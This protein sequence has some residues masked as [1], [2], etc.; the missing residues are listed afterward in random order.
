MRELVVFILFVCSIGV[1]AETFKTD[2]GV[3][4]SLPAENLRSG[5]HIVSGGYSSL[6]NLNYLA[7]RQGST[8]GRF[9]DLCKGQLKPNQDVETII[10]AIQWATAD[11]D[12]ALA[13][14]MTERQYDAACV[15]SVRVISKNQCLRMLPGSN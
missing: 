7:T 3:V 8:S 15:G 6:L 13:I 9:Y 5:N 4:S 10:A 1:H 14:D 2:C 12:L 11:S